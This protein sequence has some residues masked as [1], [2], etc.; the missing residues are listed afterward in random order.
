MNRHA[1]PVL[2]TGALLLGSAAAQAALPIGTSG[3]PGPKRDDWD[4]YRFTDQ[5]PSPFMTL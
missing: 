4:V 1:T 3:M 5:E 2:L